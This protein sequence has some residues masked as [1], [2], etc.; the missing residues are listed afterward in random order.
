MTKV[1][2]LKNKKM[3]RGS[4]T[5]Q[6]R[7]LWPERYG[8]RCPFCMKKSRKVCGAPWDGRATNKKECGDRLPEEIVQV[9][10]YEMVAIPA[11]KNDE[12]RF[13]KPN[14]MEA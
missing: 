6:E 3:R 9:E 1:F 11:H 7:V 5:R 8:C 4:R 12:R 13:R 10:E 2:R 14:E